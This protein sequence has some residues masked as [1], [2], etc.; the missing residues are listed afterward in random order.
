M[1]WF[2]TGGTQKSSLVTLD[3]RGLIAGYVLDGKGGGAAV[4]WDTIRTWAPEKGALWLHL[5][6]AD[7]TV[8][9]WL[10]NE[11]GIEKE[12]AD[13]LLA[14]DVRP[15]VVPTAKGLIVNLKGINLNPGAD[16][17]DMV[18]LRCYLEGPRLITTRQRRI[19]AIDDIRLRIKQGAGPKDASDA[20]VMIAHSLMVRIG[21]VLEEMGD[22]VDE[23]EDELIAGHSA[24]L[25]DRLGMVRR[26][27]VAV[28][29]HLAP[30]REALTRLHMESSALIDDKDRLALR[31]IA[32]STTRYVE[33]LDA[34]RER[35]AVLQD[36]WAGRLA[37]QQNRNSYLLAVVAG[38]V[39][40][41]TL[42]T[43]VLGVNIGG[44]HEGHAGEDFWTLV[45]VL[46]GLGVAQIVLY[47]LMRWL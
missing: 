36:E 13:A 43:A 38:V 11:A 23:L 34:V 18:A 33:D 19:M 25:R 14:P 15:R 1:N 30:Q 46:A 47:R 27:A 42:I 44:M 8:R 21:H 45:C 20:L 32:D 26:R 12:V 35:A 3:E 17:E 4:E 40:P 16:P 22:A 31:E 6:R 2:S 24:K 37:E 5:N 39:L 29:R 28:R 9:H 10:M 7:K 41:L